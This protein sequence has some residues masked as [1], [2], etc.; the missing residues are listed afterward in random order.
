MAELNGLGH[1][2]EMAPG[3]KSQ[4]DVFADGELIFSKQQLGR[5]PEPGEVAGL[6]D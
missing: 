5:Y 6:L 4:F 2:A 3:E 1:I